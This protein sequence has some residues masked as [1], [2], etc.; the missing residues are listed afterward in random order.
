MPTPIRHLCFALLCFLLL[1]LLVLFKRHI[2]RDYSGLGGPAIHRSFNHSK[3]N[4][5]RLPVRDTLQAGCPSSHSTN[6][7]GEQKKSG[8]IYVDLNDKRWI[9]NYYHTSEIVRW[10]VVFFSH[11]T[12]QFLTA[13][14]RVTGSKFRR[15][16]H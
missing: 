16:C 13:P 3:N 9:I 15:R 12:H 11:R 7:V 6:D 14:L 10:N 2:F 8:L 4:V 5:R 1:L